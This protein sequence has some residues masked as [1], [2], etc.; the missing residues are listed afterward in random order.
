MAVPNTFGSDYLGQDAEVPVG[1][2]SSTVTPDL[3]L[4]VPGEC[5][6][7]LAGVAV[8]VLLALLALLFLSIHLARMAYYAQHGA[9]VNV[10]PL[11]R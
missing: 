9:G 3:I 6:V 11:D 10:F 8:L 2:T 4:R 7:P 5:V 1:L